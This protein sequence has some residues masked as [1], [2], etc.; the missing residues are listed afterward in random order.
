MDEEYVR[1]LFSVWGTGYEDI[2]QIK[3][4]SAS[5][6]LAIGLIVAIEQVQRDPETGKAKGFAFIEFYSHAAAAEALSQ[7]KGRD[8][9]GVLML[10]H[11][12]NKILRFSA[13]LHDRDR[14]ASG[15]WCF[16]LGHSLAA[17]AV[18]IG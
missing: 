18:S 1:S 14:R 16:A 4:C 15:D 2:E 9:P 8:I 7:Y 3:V 17:R 11:P 12:H 5:L 13:A 10:P 6:H